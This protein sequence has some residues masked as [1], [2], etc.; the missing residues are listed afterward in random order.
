M[1][2]ALV[3]TLLLFIAS[4]VEMNLPILISMGH[5]LQARQWIVDSSGPSALV[6]GRQ[7]V[8]SGKFTAV[9]E[10][11][12]NKDC[13]SFKTFAVVNSFSSLLGLV[14]EV[15]HLFA[16]HTG[17]YLLVFRTGKCFSM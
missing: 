6:L 14:S 9:L 3:F 16:Y 12:L 4:V 2:V 10:K 15:S 5:I 17:T 13:E 11:I 8:R 7:L 1:N